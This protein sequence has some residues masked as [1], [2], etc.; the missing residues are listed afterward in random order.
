MS[1]DGVCEIFLSVTGPVSGEFP[2]VA[3]PK[4]LR[5]AVVLGSTV[6]A[7]PLYAQPH[8]A[9]DAGQAHAASA[10]HEGASTT[11]AFSVGGL[12]GTDMLAIGHKVPGH[13]PAVEAALASG[14]NIVTLSAAGDAVS[15][16]G[17]SMSTTSSVITL[18][19]NTGTFTSSDMGKPICLTGAM[20]S[21]SATFG[22]TAPGVT[23]CGTI[24]SIGTVGST[25]AT[26]SF[27]PTLPTPS[28]GISDF[29]VSAKGSGYT[30]GELVTLSIH[31]AS[32][33]GTTVLAVQRVQEV[34]A[35][36]A[37][38]LAG[39]HSST[40]GTCGVM[41]TTG[42]IN[43][44]ATAPAPNGYYE[45]IVTSNG[46]SITG[47]V[48]ITNGGD[49]IQAPLSAGD[50]IVPQATGGAP[51]CGTITGAA[52]G[53][54]SPSF[55]VL[56]V[57]PHNYGYYTSAIGTSTTAT[58]VSSSGTGMGLTLTTSSNSFEVSGIATWG[59]DASS[60]YATAVNA[61]NAGRQA[62]ANT[63]LYVPPGAYFFGSTISP[64][65]RTGGGLLTDGDNAVVFYMSPLYYTTNTPATG[66][67]PL[68]WWDSQGS[69]KSRPFDG[70]S[71]A[72]SE[73][74]GPSLTGGISIVGD[75]TSNVKQV[76]MAFCGSN[77]FAE[78]HNYQFWN[79]PGTGLEYGCLGVNDPVNPGGPVTP[80]TVSHSRESRFY[81]IRGFNSGASPGSN[82]MSVNY[83]A[84]D[85]NTQSTTGG[86][87]GMDD[88]GFDNVELF[89]NHGTGIILHA[90]HSGNGILGAVGFVNF[91][92]RVR[93]EGLAP[94]GTTLSGPL[95]Q[96]GDTNP[97]MDGVVH[98]ISFPA[99]MQLVDPYLGWAGILV[100]STGSI[101]A[102]FP[103]N[104]TTGPGT[105]ISGGAPYGNG[106]DIEY[107]KVCTFNI[108]FIATNGIDYI[109]GPATDTANLTLL[110][111]AGETS[112]WSTKIDS[113]AVIYQGELLS[114][115]GAITP[116]P[117]LP[118]AAPP[119][120][121]EPQK[122]TPR[123]VNLPAKK[124]PDA[125]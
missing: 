27:T 76:G 99:G 61:V 102:A 23:E 112:G 70:A 15:W 84:I 28:N 105:V 97:T 18:P 4:R 55:G 91:T 22:T 113:T 94:D 78:I 31:N 75:R 10:P 16:P 39:S 79:L 86:A 119:S 114:S 14:A 81:N 7:G 93:V 17:A 3:W 44:R 12:H 8:H 46:T 62:G 63:L 34:T 98:D 111:P 85:I 1:R 47:V 67:I 2:G 43:T 30:T 57:A 59:S 125:E 77:Y 25:T 96:V 80:D 38:V 108:Q 48:S 95:I 6:A 49:Y 101:N 52:L 88:V 116:Q 110:V 82:S 40:V 20:T 69:E 32:P 66:F 74:F 117:S 123:P 72:F 71:A 45:A 65:F 115:T 87:S 60:A 64:A 90:S 83:A 29:T 120:G 121:V 104:I 107:C 89:G 100:T 26:L 5:A 11:G 19:P 35:G 53:T 109:Q 92:G 56:A 58:Q 106:L 37:T 24:S 122:R 21:M 103:Y 73:Q 36:A 51:A 50:P 124:L 13:S 54:L 9:L 118:P 41:G 33:V 42:T 68:V